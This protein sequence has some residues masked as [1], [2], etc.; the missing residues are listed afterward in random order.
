MRTGGRVTS[1]AARARTRTHAPARDGTH[2]F[3]TAR[4]RALHSSQMIQLSPDESRVLGVLIEKALT[5]PDQYP[6]SLNAVVS[7]ANQKSNRE[8]VLTMG[9]D[10]CH[11]ALESLRG[12]GLVV[13][14]D[15]VGNR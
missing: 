5:T 13:R 3:F 4:P 2:D 10:P 6:L 12:K 9:E 8:P 1:E 11:E 14:V 15:V 7:G